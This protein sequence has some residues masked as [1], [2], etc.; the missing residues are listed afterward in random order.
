MSEVEVDL[1]ISALER[2]ASEV[3]ELKRRSRPRRPIVIEFCGSPKSGKTSCINSLIIFLKRNGFRTKL[4]AERASVCPINEKFDPLFNLW[5]SC[6]AIIELAERLAN[7]RQT[8]DVIV[9]DR[10]V[11][12]GLCWFSWLM[13]HGHLDSESYSRLSSF[14]TMK[15]FR[16]SIDLVYV[17]K[18]DPDVSMEREYATLLTRKEGSIMNRQMLNTY[19][20]TIDGVIAKY[21][22]VFQRVESIDTTSIAQNHVSYAVTRS[23]LEILRDVTMEKVGFIEAQ[24]VAELAS[25]IFHYREL[26]LLSPTL[27]YGNRDVVET[28]SNVLQ[29]IPVVVVTNPSR[30]KVLVLKKRD[31][32]LSSDSPERGHLL[33]YAGGHIRREDNLNGQGE[34]LHSVAMTALEREVREELGISISLNSDDPL[35]I[36]DKSTPVSKRHLAMCYVYETNLDSLKTRLDAYEFVAKGR[37]RSGRFLPVMEVAR[38]PDLEE[39]SRTILERLF[40]QPIGGR[41]ELSS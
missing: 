8:L 2:L 10:G 6:S 5:T 38:E 7:D 39:W 4:L 1:D 11:F 29:P 37:S 23:I 31:T 28:T 16:A 3:L 41:L 27:S 17:F 35:C 34:P 33:V 22:G 26:K 14:L 21:N 25:R 40:G 13:E 36:W 15:K 9:S 18:A 24:P 19:L 20:E 32:S 30:D 12:D